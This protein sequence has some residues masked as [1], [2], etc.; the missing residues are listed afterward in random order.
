MYHICNHMFLG[1]L[2]CLPFSTESPMRAGSGPLLAPWTMPCPEGAVCWTNT[3]S[4]LP[5]WS[6]VK[7][8]RKVVL[9]HRESCGYSHPQGQRQTQVVHLSLLLLLIRNGYNCHPKGLLSKPLIWCQ[10]YTARAILPLFSGT[11]LF[12]N[13]HTDICKA[14]KSFWAQFNGLKP[15]KDVALGGRVG[16]WK[17]VRGRTWVET[18]GHSRI[19]FH[20]KPCAGHSGPVQ[21]H[22]QPP[23]SP[24]TLISSINKDS[25]E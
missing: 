15:L 17:G 12:E 13:I 23:H 5:P 3:L 7:E 16:R 1:S 20:T 21:F 19:T 11:R 8:V 9:N 25:P 10:E 4:N 22:C 18:G 2:F 14:E 24:A 6:R